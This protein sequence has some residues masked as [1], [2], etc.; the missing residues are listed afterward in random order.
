LEA[1]RFATFYR[2]KQESTFREED[3]FRAGGFADL[4]AQE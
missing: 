3:N 1:G 4:I 2:I